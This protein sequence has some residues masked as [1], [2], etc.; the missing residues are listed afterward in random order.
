MERNV[1]GRVV[2]DQCSRCA[3]QWFD[4]HEIQPVMRDEAPALTLPPEPEFAPQ[5]DP[6]PPSCPRDGN[7][8]RPVRLH[9]AVL[10]CCGTCAGILASAASWDRLRTAGHRQAKEGRPIMDIVA[11]LN[12]LLETFG[13]S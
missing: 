11:D 12:R 7:R 9:G 13:P 1:L 6:D 3:A 5:D 8:L 2:V 10:W 4:R